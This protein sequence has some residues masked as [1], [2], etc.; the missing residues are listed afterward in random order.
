MYNMYIVQR[1]VHYVHCT[2]YCKLCASYSVQYAL[3]IYTVNINYSVDQIVA[4]LVFLFLVWSVA[5]GLVVYY[6]G[7][8]NLNIPDNQVE[9]NRGATGGNRVPIEV[10]RVAIGGNRGQYRTIGAK[11]RAKGWQ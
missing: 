10:N 5:L 4:V 2:V 1:T 8:Y 7:V 9:D 11:G 6:A 3:N